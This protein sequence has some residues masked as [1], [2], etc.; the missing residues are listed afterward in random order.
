MRL[1]YDVGA[2][3]RDNSFNDSFLDDCLVDSVSESKRSRKPVRR[4]AVAVALI[5]EAAMVSGL[6]L[7]PLLTTAR[8]VPGPMMIDR[9]QEQIN[10]APIG[11]SRPSGASPNQP[12]PRVT[13]FSPPSIPPRIIRSPLPG[14][15]APTAPLM[16]DFG[17]GTPTGFPSWGGFALGSPPIAPPKP[18]P[19]PARIVRRSEHEEEGQLLRRVIPTY[20]EIA[21]LARISGTVELVVLVGRDGRVKYVQVLSGSTLLAASAKAGVEQWRYRPTILDGQA[22]E[23]ETHV[24]VH[25]VLNE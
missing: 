10:P 12:A 16:Q 17:P 8:L 18:A 3:Q 6:A 20:P 13:L 11:A 24:T 4:S 15:Q 19:A 21:R 5:F 1:K 9:V 7:W 2:V 22:V 25:F 23:V 14:P